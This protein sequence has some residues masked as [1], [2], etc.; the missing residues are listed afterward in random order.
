MHWRT[1]LKVFGG[2]KV[3][4]SF[5]V[6][7][8]IKVFD[9]LK[10]FDSIEALTSFSQAEVIFSKRAGWPVGCGDFRIVKGG[11]VYNKRR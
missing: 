11:S 3:L 5:K 10:V 1:H 2:L 9:S 8:N 6:F 7:D 4:D